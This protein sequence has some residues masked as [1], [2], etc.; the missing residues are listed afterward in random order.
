MTWGLSYDDGPTYYSTGM[1][2]HRSMLRVLI[3]TS[4]IVD[5]LNYVNANSLKTTFFIVGSRALSHPD[6]LQAEYMAGHQV[7]STK[8]HIALM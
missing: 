6:I 4:C 3:I 1:R 2:L 8:S 5:L 7:E